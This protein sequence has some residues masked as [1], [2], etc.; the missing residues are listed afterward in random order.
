M[1]GYER[2]DKGGAGKD[3]EKK[4]KIGWRE[5]EC[6]NSKKRMETG[7]KEMEKRGKRTTT[8]REE[9][10]THTDMCTKTKREETKE[11]KKEIKR[12]RQI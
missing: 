12:Q 11:W 2:Q 8:Y 5:E 6:R 1:E 3:T 10:M 4:V 9:K 7:I